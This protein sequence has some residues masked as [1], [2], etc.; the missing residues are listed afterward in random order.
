[1]IIRYAASP[2]GGGGE[3]VGVVGGVLAFQGKPNHKLRGTTAMSALKRYL[4]ILSR[5]SPRVR[6]A[7]VLALDLGICIFAALLA[8]SLRTG[9]WRIFTPFSLQLI[10]MTCAA[11]LVVAPTQGVYRSVLRFA[12]RQSIKDLAASCGII[13]LILAVPLVVIRMFDSGPRTLVIV[14]PLV[15]FM[16]LATSRIVLSALLRDTLYSQHRRGSRDVLVYGAGVAGREL[17]L[18]INDDPEFHVVGFVDD[19][20]VLRGR[21]LDGHRIWHSSELR[22]VLQEHSI[23]EVLLAIPTA[24]RARRRTIVE[25]IQQMAPGVGVRSL[26]NIA[27]IASGRVSVGDL[28]EVQIEELLG[29]D[30]VAPDPRLMSANIL[31]RCVMV[32]GAGG[33]IGSELCRQIVMQKPSRI[34]LA[35]RSELALYTIEGELRHLVASHDLGVAIE[36]KLVDIS[37]ATDMERVYRDCRPETVF[38]AAAYK[39][40]P[41]VEADPIAG[42]RNNVLGTYNCCLLGEKFGV[43]NLTL[44]STDKAVRPSSVMGASKRVCELIVQARAAAQRQTTYSAVRFGNVLGSSGSVV[45]LFRRQIAGGGPVTITHRD[46]TRYFMTVSEAAQLVVQAGAMAKGGEIFL[47]DM[48]EPVRIEDL[49]KMMIQL[50]GL[51]HA[52]DGDDGD[53]EIVE[54]GLRPGEKIHEELLIDNR[55]LPT[56]HPRIVKASES[57]ANPANF[58]S[59][60]AELLLQMEARDTAAALAAVNKMLSRERPA[61]TPA[62]A[63]RNKQSKPRRAGAGRPAPASR[64]AAGRRA[65]ET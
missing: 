2:P 32:T 62:A 41:L 33:S 15:L 38:H 49:A 45:P 44:V 6:T 16:M 17:T 4:L 7:M 51:S 34:V 20:P 11:W 58:G 23:D 30:Q 47:L 24:S 13:S 53:I 46:A 29:R 55:G 56:S 40:V 5:F 50:S 64:S 43:K 8:Y 10:V 28:R 14:L 3:L 18:S 12:G 19:S 60:F 1:M 54:I 48:G 9:E 61:R 25:E 57:G 65:L 42:I 37:D 36:P 59:Q 39:H 31:D 22:D 26:P 63:L 21:R 52:A 27:E 35:E